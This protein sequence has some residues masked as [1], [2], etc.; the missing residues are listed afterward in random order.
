MSEYK[1]HYP[2]LLEETIKLL[3][4][5]KGKIF[6]DCTFGFGGHSREILKKGA[7]VIGI[8]WDSQ[9]AEKA[10]RI[11][12]LILEN[13]NYANIDKVALKHN[14]KNIDGILIDLGLSS[15][16]LENSCRGFSFKEEN[17]GLDM[18]YSL[19]GKE[20]A[21]DI[22]NDYTKEE[23]EEIFKNY[24]ELRSARKF[25]QQIYESRKIKRIETVKDLKDSLPDCTKKCLAMIFQALRI[26]ANRELENLKI[27]MPKAFQLLG[28]NGRL[29]IISFHS[30]EDRIVKN[31]F[32][33][34][35]Q[36]GLAEI[37]T[38]KPLVASREELEKNKRSG[39][40]K[41][42]VIQKI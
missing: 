6:I 16:D 28:R 31:Y 32:R 22:L 23:L 14:L 36:E 15:W 20:K 26:E 2:V 30:L 37:L 8:E 29:A 35:K 11:E 4:P 21:S 5:E 13:D 10:E 3:N 19:N 38:K 25:A 39:S 24:G 33:D 42:R 1:D 34:L 41:L 7:K 18:R 17:Q 12:G 40:A 9:V 27:V